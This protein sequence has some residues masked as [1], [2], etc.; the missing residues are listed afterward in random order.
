L[1]EDGL[2]E[3][4]APLKPIDRARQ[5]QFS[6]DVEFLGQLALPL[7][8]ELGGTE[9]RQPPGL[10]TIEEL[11]GDE[12]RFDGLPNS[13]V[14]GDQQPDGI[15]PERHEERDELIRPGFD[16]DP[17]EGA[18]R[19]SARSEAQANRVTEEAAR[20]MI[21]DPRRVWRIEASWLD[22]LHEGIDASDLVVGTA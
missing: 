1:V 2:V 15:K 20:A 19:P 9:N 13:H 22:R 10:T 3:G 5:D 14:V 18:E 12:A 17:T 21:A 8:G 11:A 4:P 7:F 16:A 6:L